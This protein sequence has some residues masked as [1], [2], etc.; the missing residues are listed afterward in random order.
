MNEPKIIK[1]D[2]IEYIQKEDMEIKYEKRKEGPWEIGE[3]YFIL[4]V[5]MGLSGVLVDVTPQELVLAQAAWVADTGRFSDFVCGKCEPNE[6]EP[7]PKNQVVLV[8]RGA[9]I[10][11]VKIN[12][13]FIVQK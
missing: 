13:I 12:K 9:L 10:D 11:A 2:D 8:G 7:F 1:I 5:T 4:T 3:K 6:V